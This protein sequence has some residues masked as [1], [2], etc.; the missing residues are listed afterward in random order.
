MVAEEDESF[1]AVDVA[2]LIPVY[3]E[4]GTLLDVVRGAVHALATR[5]GFGHVWVVNDGST[6]WS[7]AIER[8]VKRCGPVT[9]VTRPVNEGKGAVLKWAFHRIDARIIVVIDADGEYLP[10]EI[11]LLLDPI[12]AD[13]AD[14]VMGVR[15][16]GGRPRPRQYLAT[17]WVNRLVTGWFSLLAG[18]RITTD[19]LSGLYAF[20]SECVR[21]VT[22]HEPRFSYTPELIWK[23]LHTARPRW[24]DV[25]ISYRFRNY[26]QGKSIRW[27]ETFTILAAIGR[28]RTGAREKAGCGI[29]VR[30]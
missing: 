8:A 17:Y 24:L 25:P 15:Y 27:W 11:P 4:G 26:A 12:L 7:D 14:W 22:L 10:S 5:P 21:Q 16:G 20:R 13:K 23:V 6:D 28:Y 1:R 19:L 3:N 18:R 30:H 2:V 9:V 29:P